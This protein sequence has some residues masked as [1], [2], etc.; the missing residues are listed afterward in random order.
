MVF[1]VVAQEVGRAASKAA[2]NPLQIRVGV[3]PKNDVGRL[4]D[5]PADGILAP[6]RPDKDFGTSRFKG[7]YSQTT[8]LRALMK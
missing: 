7:S 8:Q 5:V 3:R 4:K 1:P 2:L 6:R